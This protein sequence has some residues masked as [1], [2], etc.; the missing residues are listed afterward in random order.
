MSRAH[1]E[2]VSVVI[3]AYNRSD[4][5]GETL[6]SVLA[7]TLRPH[8]IIVVD[9]GSTDNTADV[10]A[11]FSSDVRLIQQENQGPGAARNRGLQES[12]GDVIHFMDSD[13]LVSPNMHEAQLRVLNSEGADFAYGPWVKTRFD[14]PSLHCQKVVIQQRAVPDTAG[15]KQWVMRGWVSVFQ[16]CLIRKSLLEKAG[17]YRTNIKSAD[18]SELLFRIAKTGAVFAHT[19]ETLLVYRVHPEGQISAQN[20]TAQRIDWVRYLDSVQ[21]FCDD[22]E[23]LDTRTDLAFTFRKIEAVRA[24][25]V[26]GHEETDRLAATV[27]RPMF[28]L[29]TLAKPFVRAVK[30]GRR[31]RYGDSYIP[32]F[33]PGP[34]T[35]HQ[36]TLIR[37]MCCELS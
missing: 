27:S 10:V 16:A 9:D 14:G 11:A 12:T 19:P 24:A 29:H 20:S 30:R 36:R 33:C 21:Q 8:E 37:Q 15:M 6:Q 23:R 7:Q 18:D 25:G 2:K 13:D 34:M 17:P 28:V 4:L 5:I 32:A 31:S 1:L 22:S 3:P 26:Q 35:E